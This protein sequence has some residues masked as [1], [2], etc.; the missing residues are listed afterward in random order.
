VIR[1]VIAALLLVGC[2]DCSG[3]PPGDPED[4]REM[5]RAKRHR[6][7]RTE[8]GVEPTAEPPDHPID[9]A[10]AT[11][12][13][14]A[15]I[16]SFRATRARKYRTRA[17]MEV[18]RTGQAARSS[19]WTVEFMPPDRRR[20][21]MEMPGGVE[22]HMLA[23]G[24][25]VWGRQ[26]TGDRWMAAPPN[27][28]GGAGEIEQRMVEAIESGA[29]RAERIGPDQ[30]SNRE[31]MIYAIT[32]SLPAVGPQAGGTMTG[33]V[34]IGSNG[35]ALRFQGRTDRPAESTVD[36][37]YD[38]DDSIDIQPPAPHEVGSPQ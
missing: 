24:N 35:L 27:A 22:A 33:R 26:H 19:T 21:V 1:I 20:G 29:L 34:W 6:G 36:M 31:A 17:T 14:Q 15:L 18:R 12:A 16:T 2:G 10:A 4:S 7:P 5:G 3:E 25:Q 32:W 11:D 9:E 28:A 23:I 13:R 37:T 30:T 8:P 38:Y